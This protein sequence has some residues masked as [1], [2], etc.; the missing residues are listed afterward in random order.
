M[1]VVIACAAALLLVVAAAVLT[2]QDRD[3]SA[4]EEE[5]GAREE[6][7]DG[8]DRDEQDPAG[9]SE[10]DRDEGEEADEAAIEVTSAWIDDGDCISENEANN[11]TCHRIQVLVHASADA[12][13]DVSIPAWEAEDAEGE[14]HSAAWVVSPDPVSPGASRSV[15]LSF[16]GTEDLRLTG[17]RYSA[18]G[19]PDLSAEIPGY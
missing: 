9:T 19:G 17:L 10:G 7:D 11:A 18:L 4:Q 16:D 12:P 5:N 2:L 14:T 1:I 15:T 13:F 8:E 3:D 6:G